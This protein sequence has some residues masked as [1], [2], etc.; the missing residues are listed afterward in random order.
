MK[1]ST[2]LYIRHLIPAVGGACAR[3]NPALLVLETRGPGAR[4]LRNS[5]L[6]FAVG[7]L[8]PAVHV[9]RVLMSD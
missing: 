4:V 8:M 3:S 7:Q 6:D 1:L 5:S 2:F 9:E